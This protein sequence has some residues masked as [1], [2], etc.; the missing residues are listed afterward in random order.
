[1]WPA[2]SCC[3]ITHGDRSVLNLVSLQNSL[4][5]QWKRQHWCIHGCPLATS[6]HE[7]SWVW[8]WT[9]GKSK[10]HPGKMLDMYGYVIYKHICICMLLYHFTIQANQHQEGFHNFWKMHYQWRS[11]CQSW[12]FTDIFGRDEGC[13]TCHKEKGGAKQIVAS[14][15]S[16]IFHIQIKIQALTENEGHFSLVHMSIYS[17]HSEKKNTNI[18]KI[19]QPNQDLANFLSP[20]WF[21]WKLLDHHGIFQ[22]LSAKDLLILVGQICLWCSSRSKTHAVMESWVFPAN[23]NTTCYK[24]LGIYELYQVDHGRISHQWHIMGP[25]IRLRLLLDTMIWP[26]H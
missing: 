24:T 23:P 20:R 21:T 15:A 3:L 17:E 12:L 16:Y 11:Q 10:C 26:P 8:W 22:L 5:W 14:L 7:K 6:A 4:P 18:N 9:F 19:S 25:T 13:S 1:M 2:I